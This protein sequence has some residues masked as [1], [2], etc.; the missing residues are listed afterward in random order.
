[1]EINL[2]DIE[3]KMGLNLIKQ[4]KNKTAITS[5]QKLLF[6]IRFTIGT[7]IAH[8]VNKELIKDLVV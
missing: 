2:I 3:K 6:G 5:L 8:E 7:T 4:D 1:M